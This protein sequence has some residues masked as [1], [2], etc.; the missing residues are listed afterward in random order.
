VVRLAT[1]LRGLATMPRSGWL[2]LGT[3][4][5]AGAALGAGLAGSTFRAPGWKG[6]LVA[7]ML[8]SLVRGGWRWLRG[9]GARMRGSLSDRVRAFGGGTYGTMTLATLLYLEGQGL[10][11]EWVRAHGLLDFLEGR[12]VEW[13]VGF[14]GD[15]FRNALWAG[16]WPLYWFREHGF[17]ALG[18]AG[19]LTSAVDTLVRSLLAG[20]RAVDDAA[21]AVEPA[22][23][24]AARIDAGVAAP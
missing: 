1:R 17:V 24:E 22:T 20:E 3:I 6:M 14:G 13:L 11:G 19:A 7:A 5:A 9:G 10:Y 21:G 2:A 18:V 16:L 15:S 4:C 12:S 8:A 23:V